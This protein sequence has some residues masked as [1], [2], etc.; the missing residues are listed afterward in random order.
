MRETLAAC[1]RLNQIRNYT[2]TSPLDEMRTTF[3]MGPMS[4]TGQNRK[5][6]MRVYVF[7]FT[8]QSRHRRV[9]KSKQ[10]TTSRRSFSTHGER[11]FLSLSLAKEKDHGRP[12]KCDSYCQQA[13]ALEQGQAD[14]GKAAAALQT[15]LVDSDEAP[16]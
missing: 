3:R 9:S 1:R 16:D 10:K 13:P 14:R 7:R 11:A 6:S 15:C 4:E 8:P 5:S 12:R 2:S